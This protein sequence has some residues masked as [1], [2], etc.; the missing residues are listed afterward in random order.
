[1]NSYQRFFAE[2]KRRQVFKVIW[3]YGIVG[4]GVLQVADIAL[5]RLGLPDWTVTF[6]LAVIL[7]AFPVA[8]ILAWAFEMTPEGVRRTDHASP[9][10]IA[11]IV[12][13]P[14][15][16][17][18]PS[19]L[20]ALVGALALVGSTWWLARRTAPV[21][22]E[23]SASAESADP[24]LQLALAG[25]PTDERPSIAVLPFADMSPE[26]DQAYFSDGITEEILNTLV[27]IRDLKVAARTSAF[28]FRG[29]DL[30]MRAIGDSLGVAYL[31]EG[32]VR[33]SGNQLR[34]TAQLIDAADGSHLWSESYDR[35]MDDVFAIQTEIAEAIAGELRVPLGL[36]RDELVQPTADLEAYDLYLAGRG[37][38]R[39][40]GTA[41]REAEGLFEA[42]IARDSTWAPAW[43]GLAEARELLSWYPEAWDEAPDAIDA[44][45]AIVERYWR[46]GRVAA[47]RALALDPDN[48]SAL[49][50]LGSVQ[51]NLREW[52]AAERTYLAALSADPDNPEAHQQYAELLATVGR[53]AEGRR[54]AERA[55]SLDPAGIRVFWRAFAA[56]LDDRPETTIAVGQPGL[57]MEQG[58]TLRSNLE[59]IV[60]LAHL[61]LERWEDLAELFGAPDSTQAELIGWL[62]AE[63][64]SPQY[65]VVG[66][67]WL[68]LSAALDLQAGRVDPAAATLRRYAHHKRVMPARLWLPAFDPIRDHP[69]FRG[70][71]RE[72]DLDGR[73]PQRTPRT[74]ASAP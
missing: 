67:R 2:L 70:T 33:K 42:A 46:E 6:M 32:S 39:H 47:E 18:W 29:R 66:G 28:A 61:R 40:R 57:A 49:V 24:R 4:F 19:G 65:L 52:D 60:A 68:A 56:L 50:A 41:L 58:R 17:R 69:E 63:F 22:S 37:R 10:E 9:E 31:I 43:A 13:A 25:D 14:A 16:T 38:I 30:D 11:A 51:R 53:I 21:E 64:Q 36:D 44:Q 71:L 20:L 34:I 73:T 23:A 7:L 27:K 26:A 45:N 3:W 12:A 35:A 15:S 5:P 8:L 74:E 62:Q 55:A 59:Q 54:S 48:A 72:L 1:M